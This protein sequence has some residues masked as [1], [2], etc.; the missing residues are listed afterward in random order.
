MKLLKNNKDGWQYEMNRREGDCLRSLLNQFPI[1][2]SNHAKISRTCVE[3][4]T[5]EREKLLN[6]SMSQHRND[7]KKLA[8][9][10]M[11][12]DKLKAGQ[13][14]CRLLISP[15]EREILFQILND[16][17]VGCW[18]ELGEPENLEPKTSPPSHKELV[19]YNLMNLAGYFEHSLLKQ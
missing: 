2:E 11:S 18:R 14:G 1:T 13:N 19:F 3:P 10:L 16:I 7:L 9:N 4:K 17:R 8:N 5:V 12:A 6:E 15:E